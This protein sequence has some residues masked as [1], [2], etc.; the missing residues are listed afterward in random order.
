MTPDEIAAARDA[1]TWLVWD[2]SNGHTYIGRL[3]KGQ[4]H[5]SING[6][7]YVVTETRG[8]AEVRPKYLRIAT[9]NDMLKYG[10]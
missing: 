3:S 1:G 8:M 5:G 10:E 7:W 2:A 6:G 4:R 9:P